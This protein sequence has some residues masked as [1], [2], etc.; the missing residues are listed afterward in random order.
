MGKKKRV[1]DN[2]ISDVYSVTLGGIEQ[3]ILVEG[4]RRELP[5]V[6]TL[7]GGPGTPIPFSV[8]CRGLFPVFTERFIMIYWDQL[9]CGI[10][11][12]EI[13][14]LFTIDSYVDMTVDLVNFAKKKFPDNPIYLF[15]M[16]WG[17]VLALKTVCRM[18][19]S[20]TGVVTWGQVTKQLFF[21]QEVFDA[22]EAAGL[23]EKKMKKIK[24]I[25][26]KAFTPK[27]MQFFTG[28]IRKYT[29]G[30]E[31]KNGK[32]T[33]ASK[34]MFGIM[35]S[36]D[37]SL[38]DFKAMIINGC[39][40]NTKLWPELLQINLQ[41]LLCEVKI[42]YYILQGDTDIVTSTL[43]LKEIVDESNNPYLRY[44]LVKNS[45]HIPG[46][47]GMEGVLETLIEMTHG[48]RDA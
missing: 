39:A 24:S 34:I 4:K 23:S 2:E 6:I 45:G 1:W 21:N 10:N 35:K 17:S 12:Y 44:K 25:D 22:L 3:K 36:P 26:P 15:G 11:D 47:E 33:P 28:C 27:E 38:R 13:K 7:H 19:T 20:I 30:Y 18:Q 31:N 8:G 37:Y 48:G 5:I 14:D 9:G 29:N 40:K 46:A 41:P 42:P 16:S 32:K 43:L